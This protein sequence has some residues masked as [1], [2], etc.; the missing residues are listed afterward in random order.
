[1]VAACFA[2]PALLPAPAEMLWHGKICC[3]NVYHGQGT[4]NQLSD[5]DLLAWIHAVK[6][7]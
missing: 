1:M 7:E 3:R 2:L 4:G 6:G 5:E